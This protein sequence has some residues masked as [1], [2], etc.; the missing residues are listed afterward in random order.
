[1][2]LESRQG[3]TNRVAQSTNSTKYMKSARMGMLVMSEH[4]AWLGSATS[5]PLSKYGKTLWDVAFRVSTYR[6]KSLA[7]L[8]LNSAKKLLCLRPDW[9]MPLPPATSR[10]GLNLL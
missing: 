8:A 10:I 3:R 6:I 1:M 4:Q 5:T 2:L 7:A 9:D